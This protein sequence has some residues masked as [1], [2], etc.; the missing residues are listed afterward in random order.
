MLREFLR[1]KISYAVVTET[2]LYYEGSITIDEEVMLK[3]GLLPGEKVEVLNVNN[4]ARFTTYV[5]K[6]K[7]N[8]GIFCLNGPAARQAETGD[9]IIVLSY[10]FVDEKECPD[11]KALFVELN[12]KNKVKSAVLR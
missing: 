4:G 1:V 3:S 5:I 2:N 11:H 12:G 8:S 9:K 7:K 10:G 6:G